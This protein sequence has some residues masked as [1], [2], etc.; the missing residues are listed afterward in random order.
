MFEVERTGESRLHDAH[1]AAAGIRRLPVADAVALLADVR[2]YS[3]QFWGEHCTECAAPACHQSCDLFERGPSG[4]CRRFADGIVV[5]TEAAGSL[6]F[7]FEVLFK[8]WGQLQAVGNAFCHA[9]GEYRGRAAGMA[10]AGHISQSVQRLTGFLP[11]RWQ[12]HLTDKMRGAGNRWPQHLNRGVAQHAEGRPT[13]WRAVIGNPYP[14]PIELE[15]KFAGYNDSQHGHVYRR[16]ET[17]APGWNVIRIPIEAIAPVIDLAALFRTCLVPL[18]QEPHLLQFAYAGFVVAEPKQADAAV[19]PQ[20]KV[21]LLVVDLDHTLWDGILL[22]HADGELQLKPDVREVLTALDERG[23]LLSIASRNNEAD[24]TRVLER[25]GILHLF[26]HPQISWFPKS[27]GIRRIVS[28]LNI[29]LDSVAFIDDTPFELEEVKAAIPEVRIYDAAQFGQLPQLDE[30][31]V[32]VTTESRGRRTMYLAEGQRAASFEAS[33]L[34]YEAFLR[35]CQLQLELQVIGDDTFERVYELVQRTNQLNFSGNRYA[36]ADVSGFLADPAIV[37]I[38]MS[39]RDRMGPYGIIG[40]ALCRVS[41]EELVVSDMMYSCR[42]Q[43]K[44]VEHA[45][46]DWLVGVAERAGLARCRCHFNRTRRNNPASAVFEDLGFRREVAA[47]DHE[48]F[49]L[50]CAGIASADFPVAV[51]DAEAIAGRIAALSRPGVGH[52]AHPADA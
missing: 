38:V 42:I 16:I 1:C 19:Q 25:L 8:P 10:Q 40:F 34:D 45:F 36:R 3:L 48:E 32:P 35:D 39:C 17:L 21:K 31:D 44:R 5:H 46:L 51:L 22:E 15:V 52:E 20:Q 13:E 11:D 30:F 6:P 37:P 49:V 47:G 2:R 27:A 26:L 7:T 28:Q 43:A 50:P 4:R 9:A 12:W 33:S 41:G 14:S 18:V 23:I 29:G 24:A